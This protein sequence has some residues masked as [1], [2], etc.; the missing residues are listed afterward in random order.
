[1]STSTET[2]R[3]RPAATAPSRR[4]SNGP[5]LTNAVLVHGG[6][7]DGSG[8]QPVYRLLKAD[9][10][11]V[12]VVQN[13]TLSVG[14]DV[15][16]TRQVTNAQNGPVVHMGHPTGSG[17]HRGGNHPN[18]VAL[19]YTAAFAPDTE[20]SIDT[21][22][23]NPPP[24]APMPPILPPQDGFL[25]PDREKF[26]GSF[27]RDV[28]AHLAEFMAD[29]HVPWGWA[30]SN[31]QRSAQ[32]QR[33]WRGHRPTDHLPARRTRSGRALHGRPRS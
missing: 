25:L 4:K 24:G 14:G 18:V 15:A 9:G 32:D 2:R 8:W 5:E 12:G 7:V 10:Y 20:E 29:S 1:M 26:P 28:P 31:A 27:A 17:D 16:A 33:R 19:A 23:A 6:F 30:I 3:N 21:L 13:S 11:A 22:I